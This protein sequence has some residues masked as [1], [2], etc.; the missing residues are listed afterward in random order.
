MPVIQEALSGRAHT[1]MLAT[2]SPSS[3]NYVET[4]NTLKYAE[5]L[6]RASAHQS[7]NR[8]AA[9]PTITKVQYVVCAGTFGCLPSLLTYRT[10]YSAHD[11]YSMI[12]ILRFL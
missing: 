9:G 3:N 8:D 6:R 7:W 4:M 5:R 12:S 1:T 11:K 2:V 10:G